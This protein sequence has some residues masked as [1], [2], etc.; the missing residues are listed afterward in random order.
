M[1]IVVEPDVMP[2]GVGGF[3]PVEGGGGAGLR[4][5]GRGARDGRSQGREGRG[6]EDQAQGQY[7][8]ETFH[9]HSSC[10]DNKIPGR[11]KQLNSMVTGCQ[12]ENMLVRHVVVP[13]QC[14]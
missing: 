10:Q 13:I 11:F 7:E 1:V 2:G 12:G 6:R 9:D 5:V 8:C 4:V 3:G 14:I